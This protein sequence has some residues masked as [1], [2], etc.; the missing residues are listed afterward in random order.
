M[1][2][3]IIIYQNTIIQLMEETLL[4]SQTVTY[5][6]FPDYKLALIK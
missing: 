2:F 5:I 3:F 6:R 4:L 1:Q